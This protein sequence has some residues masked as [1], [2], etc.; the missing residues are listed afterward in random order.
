MSLEIIILWG[1]A[2]L[3][4]DERMLNLLFPN[5]LLAGFELRKF[6]KKLL[7]SS[8]GRM[9]WPFFVLEVLNAFENR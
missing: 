7:A 8:S 2:G 4:L 9:R 1:R 5:K 6:E 3:I